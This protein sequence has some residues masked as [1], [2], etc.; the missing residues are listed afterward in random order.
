MGNRLD[1]IKEHFDRDA[2]LFDKNFFR[3]APSYKEAIE[4]LVSVL[5]FGKGS[6]IRVVDLGCGTGNIAKAILERYP[7]ASVTCVD[8]SEKMIE[9]AK[10]KLKKYKNVKFYVGDLRDFKF[11]GEYD[12]VVSS[13]VLHHIEGA[14]KKLFYRKIYKCLKKN[15]VFYTVDIVL[16]SSK[17]VQ[18]TYIEKWINF[19]R[20]GCS[21]SEIKRTLRN[22]KRED[23]PAVLMNE[24]QML[25]GAGF[26]DI[27]VVCKWYYFSVYGGVKRIGK[28]IQ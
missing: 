22:H 10:A 24:L 26:K 27:D 15:G 2:Q 12:A 23:R 4:A 25:A 11:N 5:P 13:L 17:H 18:E 7:G 20:K 6:T 1:I 9:L 28:I 3:F 8:L 19:L 21:P 16:G 14:D